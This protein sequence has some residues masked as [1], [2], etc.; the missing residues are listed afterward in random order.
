MSQFN[1]FHFS[2]MSY[3]ANAL[4]AWIPL[5]PTNGNKTCLGVVGILTI[6]GAGYM[7]YLFSIM[8]SVMVDSSVAPAVGP[9][10]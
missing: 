4:P 1:S 7:T 10:V 2:T 6:L 3:N 8:N 5:E 9:G